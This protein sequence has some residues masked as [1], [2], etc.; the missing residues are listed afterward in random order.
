MPRRQR[1]AGC[2]LAEAGGVGLGW[3]LALEVG[4][5]V[6]GRAQGE[7]VTAPCSEPHCEPGTFATG[8]PHEGNV[9]IQPG[10]GADR[11]VPGSSVSTCFAP[12]RRGCGKDHGFKG[13]PCVKNKPEAPVTL[14]CAPSRTCPALA[15]PGG[16]TRR[17]GGQGS[18]TNASCCRRAGRPPPCCV[19]GPLRRRGCCPQVCP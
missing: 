7:F 8:H 10:S 13:N 11:L 18:A 14:T 5:W 3:A 16:C 4:R 6:C 15:E 12:V 19:P 1:P 2:W 17:A 9:H